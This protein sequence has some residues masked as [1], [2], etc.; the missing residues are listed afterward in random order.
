MKKNPLF[1]ASLALAFAL[2]GCSRDADASHGPT[3]PSAPA[4]AL[5]SRVE[6]AVTSDGFTPARVR[7]KAGEPLTLVVTRKIDKT[8]AKE[9]V[10]KDYGVN[11]PLA[12]NEPVEVKITP[13]KA[14]KV[15]FACGMDMIAGEIAVE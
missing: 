5:A 14:G 12:L 9:I 1:V 8:C 11:Q 6:I 4:A 15:R 7:A 3:Q 10:I 13:A 2:P